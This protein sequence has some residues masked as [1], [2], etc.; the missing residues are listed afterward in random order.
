MG[1]EIDSASPPILLFGKDFSFQ[2]D[3][4]QGGPAG[5]RHSRKPMS[6]YT[7]LLAIP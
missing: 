6:G 3:P 1:E 4:G 7:R 2:N 5:G